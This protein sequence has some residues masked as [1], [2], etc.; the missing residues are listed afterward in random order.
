MATP[1]FPYFPHRFNQDG[2]WESIC[3]ECF[4][5][6]AKAKIEKELEAH[7]KDHVCKGLDLK[8]VYARGGSTQS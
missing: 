5:T 6:V 3:S 4:L 7:E 8:A 2:M 1:R